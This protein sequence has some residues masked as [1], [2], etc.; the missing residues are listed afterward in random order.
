MYA[1]HFGIHYREIH[2]VLPG[3]IMTEKHTRMTCLRTYSRS[4]RL[5]PNSSLH[6]VCFHSDRECSLS[7]TRA[8]CLELL[9]ILEKIFKCQ[10]RYQSTREEKR[11]LTGE[12]RANFQEMNMKKVP[13][14]HP[15]TASSANQRTAV[16]NFKCRSEN[17]SEIFFCPWKCFDPLRLKRRCDKSNWSVFSSAKSP[18]VFLALA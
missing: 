14:Y 9:A 12:E 6:A 4:E 17:G 5:Q 1:R 2:Q 3:P 13:I 7:S 16:E 11:I 8:T 15:K 10:K 18:S